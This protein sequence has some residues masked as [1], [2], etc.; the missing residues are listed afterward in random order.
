M[1]QAGAVVTNDP[2]MAALVRKLR[3]Y[4][5]RERFVHYSLTGNHRLDELQAAVLRAK[6]P[7]LKQWNEARKKIAWMYFSWLNR[8]P[9]IVLPEDHPEHVW[10]IFA[11]RVTDPRG[12]DDLARFLQERGIQTA[13]RYPVP[14]H[15]QP[16]LAYLG[17]K[18]GFFPMA[19][20]WAKTN[21]SL[22]IYPEMSREMVSEVT[23]AIEKW[24]RCG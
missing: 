6:L 24:C 4:G 21:L 20:M 16:A 17:Y 9:G 8:V 3:T 19:E 1:G 5:E 13:V 15:L 7:H 10:H 18:E 23:Q 14:I 12:R 22:P 11:L 2:D